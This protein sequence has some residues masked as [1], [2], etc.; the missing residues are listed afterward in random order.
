MLLKV[1][2]SK[3]TT[4]PAALAEQNKNLADMYR[5]PRIPDAW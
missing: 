5:G 2:F 4:Q 1:D 3:S